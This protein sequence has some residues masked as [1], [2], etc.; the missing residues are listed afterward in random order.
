M[1]VT[2]LRRKLLAAL[3]AGGMLAPSAIFAANLDTN[4]AVN[5]DFENVDIN[6]ILGGAVK[7]L[8]WDAGTDIGYAY[9]HTGALDGMGNVIP[10][11]ANGGPLASGGNFYFTPNATPGDIHVAGQMTQLIDVSSGTTGSLIATGNA[12]YK[13][14]AYFS[15]YAN[16]LDFGSVYAQFLDSSMTV[17]G[18]AQVDDNDTTTWSQN[19]GGGLIPVGTA[20]VKLSIFGT[21]ITGGGPD[22]YIDNVD[23]RVTNEVIQPELAITVDRDT[24]AITL[25]NQTGQPV[26]FKSYSITSAFEALQPAS[27]KSITDNYDAG[28]SGPNQVDAAHNWSKLTDPT[29]NGDLSEADLDSGIGATLP[30]TISVSIGN[31]GAWIRTPTEDLVFQYISGSQIKQGIVQYTGHGDAPFAVGDLNTDGVINTADWIILRDNQLADLSADS[32]AEAYRLGDLTGDHLNN[33]ADFVLF[34]AAYDTFNGASAFAAMLAAVPEPSTI[35]VVLSAG[36]F[37]IPTLRR[38]SNR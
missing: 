30:H 38:R 36:V 15:S 12:A 28:N 25:K 27:W 8:N 34:K 29:A 33:H 20:T 13:M 11:Y 2:D 1:K 10:D 21:R 24:G 14:S 5:G 9:S 23:F 18:A 19:F 32:F 6:T 17:L 4:L 7:I 3:A 31:A 26:S 35:I 37:V 22:G 16:D